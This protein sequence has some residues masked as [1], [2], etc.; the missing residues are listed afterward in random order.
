MCLCLQ[1]KCVIFL[2]MLKKSGLSQHTSIKVSN[3]KFHG[4]HPV[5]AALIQACGQVDRWMDDTKMPTGAF[6]NYANA[7]KNIHTSY[8]IFPKL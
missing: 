6:R 8:A 2:A 3:I 7:P 5:E 1:A 4:N